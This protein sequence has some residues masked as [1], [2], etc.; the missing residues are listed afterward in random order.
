VQLFRRGRVVDPGASCVD[1]SSPAANV[2]QRLPD[3]EGWLGQDPACARRWEK[4]TPAT[5]SPGYGEMSVSCPGGDA[6]HVFDRVVYCP[7]ICRPDNPTWDG[8]YRP[9]APIC[10]GCGLA[11]VAR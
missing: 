3:L 8:G 7:R 5:V 4:D 9:D 2:V 10:N 1:V 11:T 6:P